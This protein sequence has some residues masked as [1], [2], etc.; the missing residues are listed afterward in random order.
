MS[1]A[2]AR[3]NL[4]R[5]IAVTGLTGAV[6]VD[7]Y[8]ALTLIFVFHRATLRGMLQW[9]ASNAL[10]D[11]AF[12]GGWNTALLGTAMHLVVSTIWAAVFIFAALRVPALLRRP[13]LSGTL[14]GLLVMLV[15]SYLVVPLGHAQKFPQPPPI[16]VNQLIAHVVFFGIP[17]A[18]VAKRSL[19]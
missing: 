6:S 9:D 5:A 8:L 13:I 1:V 18:L 17:V 11:S 14:F 7:A 3:P 4:A 12:S 15:M 2:T 16:F 19:S 10:G